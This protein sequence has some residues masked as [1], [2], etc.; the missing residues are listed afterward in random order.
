MKK[1][2]I[3]IFICMM[4]AS[5]FAQYVYPEPAM[6]FS[7]Q[8]C[9]EPNWVSISGKLD[10]N[11]G[12]RYVRMENGTVLFLMLPRMPDI[13][14]DGQGVAS[15]SV[16]GFVIGRDKI[17]VTELYVNGFMSFEFTKPLVSLPYPF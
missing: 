13:A 9:I 3:V 11:D 16:R 12:W 6:L 7:K 1:A 8:L 14:V 2:I 15:V 10:I 4:G 17:S 5:A